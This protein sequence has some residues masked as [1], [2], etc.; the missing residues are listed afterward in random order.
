MA[1]Y[2]LECENMDS[3]CE[4][5]SSWDEVQKMVE[6]MPCPMC[7]GKMKLKLSTFNNNYRPSTSFGQ[8][9]GAEYGKAG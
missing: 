1:I 2:V 6:G 8:A 3:V 4:T 9:M 7:G 5:M